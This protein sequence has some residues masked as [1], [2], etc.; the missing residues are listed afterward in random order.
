MVTV[1]ERCLVGLRHGYQAMVRRLNQLH[2]KIEAQFVFFLF[3]CV[4]SVRK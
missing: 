1:V 2:D 3:F 4:Y